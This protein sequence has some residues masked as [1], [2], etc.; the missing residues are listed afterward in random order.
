[1]K[2]YIERFCQNLATHTDFFCYHTEVTD[3]LHEDPRRESP[4]HATA[5]GKSRG[6]VIT[7]QDRCQT[8]YRCRGH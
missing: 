3:A 8:P 4:I 7:R 2:C 1:M 6:D 5:C